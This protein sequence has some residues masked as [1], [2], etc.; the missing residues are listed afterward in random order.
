MKN[1]FIENMMNPNPN[2][3]KKM[4]FFS[5]LGELYE[6]RYAADM[7]LIIALFGK[8]GLGKSYATL[9]MGCELPKRTSKLTFNIKDNLVLELKNFP[10]VFN[11]SNQNIIIVDDVSVDATFWNSQLT[12][13][14]KDIMI[15]GRRKHN[16]IFFTSPSASE[17][18][19]T[20]SRYFDFIMEIVNKS[21]HNYKTI[22][23]KKL[24]MNRSI[25][26]NYSYLAPAS[27]SDFIDLEK[28]N[29]NNSYFKH[30]NEG[31][32]YHIPLT[33]AIIDKVIF[34]PFNNISIMKEYDEKREKDLQQRKIQDSIASL[35]KKSDAEDIIEKTKIVIEK[36]NSFW[37]NLTESDKKNMVKEGYI[38]TDKKDILKNVIL[39]SDFKQKLFIEIIGILNPPS[40]MK[41]EV[42]IALMAKIKNDGFFKRKIENKKE[43]KKE[44]GNKFLKE[45]ENE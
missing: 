4:D 42:N 11:R 35:N 9:Q 32:V 21:K 8:R 7:D 29:S 10:D 20:L 3:A 2:G 34:S 26:S 22:T 36:L 28:Y 14:L 18:P 25:K 43:E 39:S 44:E 12:Q 17:P 40:Y 33:N 41:N 27:L 1:E 16:I 5:L 38:Y 6:Q 19:A 13:F 23:I 45:M 31:E 37:D 24:Q 30:Y 15:V